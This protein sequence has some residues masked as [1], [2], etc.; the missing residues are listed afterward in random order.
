VSPDAVSILTVEAAN[1]GVVMAVVD[2]ALDQAL[3]M[4]GQFEE[5]DV[6]GKVLLVAPLERAER[7]R[8]QSGRRRH[9]SSYPSLSPLT[10]LKAAHGGRYEPR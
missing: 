10:A 7:I 5:F 9:K 4:T 6:T 1:P 8:P 3:T 2:N